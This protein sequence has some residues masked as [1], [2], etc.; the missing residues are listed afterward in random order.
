M[1][2]RQLPGVRVQV[3]SRLRWSSDAHGVTVGHAETTTGETGAI[4]AGW[5]IHADEGHPLWLQA[6]GLPTVAFDAPADGETVDVADLLAANVPRP[7]PSSSPLVKG[8]RGASAYEVAVAAGFVGSEAEWLASLEGPQGDT[9]R[10]IASITDPDQDGTATVTYD[11]G[12][13]QSLPLPRGPKGD[14]GDKG[15][16]IVP[17][18]DMPGLY[19][20]RGT[21]LVADADGLYPITSIGA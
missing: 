11:D 12:T 9:G 15:L 5:L 7:L 8:D 16:S 2:K 4:P 18:P 20:M 13:T 6:R 1:Y 14:K 21:P 17:D 10:G 3:T 19:I